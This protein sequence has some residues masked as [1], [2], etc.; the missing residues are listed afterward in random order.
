MMSLQASP[1]PENN[2]APA[3]TTRTTNKHLCKPGLC[4]AVFQLGCCAKLA[5]FK[6]STEGVPAVI[7]RRATFADHADPSIWLLV[8]LA[9]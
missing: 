9:R 5:K 3:P 1:N 2:T 8:F 6:V 4:W 7:A